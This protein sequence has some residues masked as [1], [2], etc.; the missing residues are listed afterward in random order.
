MTTL[1]PPLRASVPALALERGP[2]PACWLPILSALVVLASLFAAVSGGAQ[3]AGAGVEGRVQNSASGTYL[4]NARVVVEGTTLETL[5]NFEGYFRLSGLAAGPIQ[6][7][8]SYAGME[9][10][11]A[12]V[13]LSAGG[14][15]RRDFDL[16]FAKGQ[17]TMDGSVIKLENF[18]VESTAL[19]GAAAAVNEQ[20]MAPNIKN[21]VVLDDI[22]D[23][24]DGNIG[25]YL[26]Y[27]P[28]I[29]IV[30]APQ[31]A[32]SA[33]IR[34][35]PPSGIV[36]MVDGAE[37]STPSADRSF[38]LAASS[39]GSVDRIEITKVP[40]PDRP[41]NAVGGTVNIIGKSGF[42]S[43][44][45][46]LR[47]NTYGAYNSDHRLS[48]PGLNE[49]LGSDRHSRARAIQP[50]L[51]V[52]Y[53]H[54]VSK[55]FAFTI[56]LSEL[57]RVYDMDYDSPTWDLIRGIQT[58]N[59]EQNVLQ[60]TERQLASATFDWKIGRND[61]LRLN[62]E[63]VQINT[64]TRQNIFATAWGAGATGDATF[65]QGA[66]AGNDVV[67]QTITYGDRTR[68]TSA[69]VLRYVHDG[70]VY[71]IDASANFSRSWDERKDIEHGFFRTIGT[72]QATG[73]IVRADGLDG[74]YDRRAPR[75][76]A[77]TRAGVPFDPYDNANLTMNN[78]T[79]QP[80]EIVSDMKSVA[81][82]ISRELKFGPPT[83]IKVGFTLNRQR[84]DNTSMLKTWTFAPPATVSRLVKDH[85]LTNTTLSAQSFFNDTLRLKWVSA[86]K[87][88]DLFK[89]HPEWFTLGEAAAYQS[90]VTNSKY[91]EETISAAY[92]RTDMKLLG[93]RLWLVGGVRFERTEDYGAGPL[94]DVRATFRQ[95]AA[96]NLLRDATGRFIPVT[97]DPIA[98]AKL[99]YTERGAEASRSYS[100]L[101]PSFNST[102]YVTDAL[103][104]R[105]A[106]AQTL[107]RPNLTEVIPGITVSDPSAAVRTAT[108]VNSGLQPWTANNFD[109]SVEG[110]GIK[111]AV[112]SLGLFKKDIKGFFTQTRIPAT[113]ALLESFGLSDDYIDYDI[114]TKTNGGDASIKGYEVSWRQTLF[115][116]PSWARGFQTFA[117]ATIS[118][119]SG[120]NATDF[121]PFAHKNINWGVAYLRRAF[122]F[123]FNV[124]YAY[125]VSGAAVAASATV[126][127]GTFTYVAPQ[128]TQDW[129]FEY[130]FTKRFTVY[131]GARNWNG[132]NKRTERSG[133]GT[134][135]WTRPQSYQ[136]FGTL[137]TLG[138]RSQF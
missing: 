120:P 36:F 32:G 76:T 114:V 86:T 48:P 100:D 27:T 88:F 64:P 107:G 6:L 23:L 68:G 14:T 16:S 130:R 19:S 20:K 46:S 37:V 126:P 85:D 134:P 70:N 123:R 95:D 53:A 60:T 105:A 108:I 128:I 42:N 67:R 31:T 30:G 103:V 52:N 51:D 83:V 61:S 98:T 59:T 34:G 127:A 28:G 125:K 136:N 133:P 110:Y 50:G 45:R 109:L 97:A 21:V 58:T 56:N 104:A 82:N 122:S 93:N 80:N 72:F 135:A 15:V 43:P 91:F 9:T 17:S 116:L 4:N 63:H 94:D 7:R 54:P 49:R 81:A 112:V 89:A 18:V 33:S 113:V 11:T 84:K 111:G 87:Y 71:K 106:F 101:Y 41:A 29:S 10:Q 55:T 66:A 119:V 117:N 40:T 78:P 92:V 115:F 138:L 124:A 2:G 57:T 96:G 38:D 74:I 121:T 73:L 90:G 118:R 5:T 22:G 132:A 62:F 1:P 3:P 24:G 8:V 129:S 26:K 102:F 39:S 47:I 131:G 13:A 99:R 44:R 79:S 35:L 12:S 75:L 65:T 25:E 137:V 69:A 77:T